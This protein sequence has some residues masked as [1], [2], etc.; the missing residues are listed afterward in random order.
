MHAPQTDLSVLHFP[1]DCVFLCFFHFLFICF[2]IFFR[3]FVFLLLDEILG[4]I[5]MAISFY[6]NC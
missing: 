6:R 1:Q 4:I 5:Q 3:K 2:Q